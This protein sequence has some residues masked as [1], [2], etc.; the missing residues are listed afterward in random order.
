MDGFFPLRQRREFTK[1]YQE[2]VKIHGRII[3]VFLRLRGEGGGPRLG[4]TVTRRVGGAVVR[5][6]CRRRIRAAARWGYQV[7]AGMPL[8]VVVNVKREVAEAPWSEVVAELVRCLE[9]GCTRLARRS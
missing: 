5:N 9:K 1:A 6:R 8:D 7:V 4:I 2:G 3:V